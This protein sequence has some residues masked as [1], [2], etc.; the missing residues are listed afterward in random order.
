MYYSRSKQ[1]QNDLFL[2]PL[3]HSSIALYLANNTLENSFAFQLLIAQIP[4]LVNSNIQ[5][6]HSFG[7]HLRLTA[8]CW[9]ITGFF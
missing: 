6:S 5:I 9:K 3:F 2:I 4:I 7:S 8:I 1:S